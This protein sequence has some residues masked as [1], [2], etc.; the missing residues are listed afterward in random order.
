LTSNVSSTSFPPDATLVLARSSSVRDMTVRNAGTGENHNSAAVLGTSGITQTQ[1]INV[2]AAGRGTGLRTFGIY[3]RNA[4]TTV[5]L[6]DVTASAYGATGPTAAN[7]ALSIQSEAIAKVTRGSYTSQG[8]YISRGIAIWTGSSAFLDAVAAHSESA[9]FN[10]GLYVYNSEAKIRGGSY[11]AMGGE[12][13]SAIY[14]FNTAISASKVTVT[15]ATARAEGGSSTNFA[16]NNATGGQI[17]LTGSH[18]IAS[19]GSSS[20]GI[21]NADVAEPAVILDVTSIAENGSSFNYGLFNAGVVTATIRNSSFNARGL[22]TVQGIRHAGGKLEATNVELSGSGGTTNYGMTVSG[23][24]SEV[25]MAQSVFS[26]SS[27]SVSRSGGTVTIANSHLV[28]GPALGVISCTLVSR[29]TT[30]NSGTT[31]P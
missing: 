31:C 4:G 18:F 21:Y 28:G 2:T 8:G 9:E 27:A 13:T 6:V 7:E 25:F 11:T 15:L 14:T 30:V 1:L 29:G 12:S 22:G 16:F 26:G 20:F 23:V 3:L 10:Y 24:T 17:W 19:G 5:S